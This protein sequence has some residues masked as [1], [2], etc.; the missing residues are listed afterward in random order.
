MQVTRDDAEKLAE[1]LKAQCTAIQGVELFGSVLRNGHGHDIDIVVL[2]DE[3]IAHAWWHDAAPDLHVRMGTALQPLRRVIK[4]VF[5]VLDE[6]TIRA[7]KA[8]RQARASELVGIDFT[9]IAEEYKP[10]TVLDVF[11]LPENW[12]VGTVANMTMLEEMAKIIRT[13]K[14][15]RSFLKCIAECAVR[16][17]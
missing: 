5:P 11:L 16:I 8:R 2:V 9:K 1:I 17:A 4:M 6:L 15:T 3:K 7:R 10:G 13:D 12:R 14:K